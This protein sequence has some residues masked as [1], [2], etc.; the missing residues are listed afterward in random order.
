MINKTLINK[1]V[2]LTILY[3]ILVISL[4]ILIILAGSKL[5]FLK[6]NENQY[7]VVTRMGKPLSVVKNAGLQKKT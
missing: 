6:V 2:L 3:T 5:F 7:A 4:I 1:T